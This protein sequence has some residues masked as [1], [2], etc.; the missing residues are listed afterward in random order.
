MTTLVSSL[1]IVFKR[2]MGL[3]AFGTS[4]AGFFGFGMMHKTAFLSWCGQMPSLMTQLK[5]PTR[6]WSARSSLMTSLRWHQVTWSPPGMEE[7]EVEPSASRILVQEMAGDRC[8]SSVG[9]L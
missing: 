9:R 5:R 6:A 2:A 8:S 1:P 3:K 4:Y 7:L